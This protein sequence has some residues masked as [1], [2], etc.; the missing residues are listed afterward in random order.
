MYRL[1]VRNVSTNG[2]PGRRPSLETSP[3]GTRVYLAGVPLVLTL[4][5][6]YTGAQADIRTER[7]MEESR[8]T[9]RAG[10]AAGTGPAATAPTLLSLIHI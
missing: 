10:G 3:R 6:G 4:L 5:L 1:F 2:N 9:P 7:L 8:A